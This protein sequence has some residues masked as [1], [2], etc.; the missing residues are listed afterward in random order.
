MSKEGQF[1]VEME[2]LE[3]YEF[4]ISF[5]LDDVEDLLADEPAP[6]GASKGPNPSRLLTAAAA[7]CLSASLLFC[8]TK[9]EP[10]SGSMRTSA[11]CT[12]GRND[13]GRMRI[14]R[15]DVQL[16]IDAKLEQ[17]VRA[18]RCLDL[19]ED[20][21]VVTASLRDGFDIDVE[22]VNQAGETLHKGAG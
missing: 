21:C 1:T 20:F 13:K 4:K 11:I 14:N 19:F 18:K 15:M 17:A 22:V 16:T 6:L 2:H 5:D 10:P 7:N 9:N 12:I 3:G 8:I